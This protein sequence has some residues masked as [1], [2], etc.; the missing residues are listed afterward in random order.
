MNLAIV[1]A[2]LFLSPT[3]GVIFDC[4]FIYINVMRIGGIYKCNVTNLNIQSENETMSGVGGVHKAQKQDSDVQILIIENQLCQ[5]LPNDIDRHFPN[6]YH[7][8]IRNSGLLTVDSKQ[9]KMFPKLRHLYIR[10][11]PIEVLPDNLFEFNP[12]L[13][14]INLNDNRI[15]RIGENVFEPLTKL[16]SLS[17]ERNICINN[18][19]LEEEPL[20][21]LIKEI[22]TKCSNE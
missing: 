16:I 1:A 20:K 12:L 17:V 18:F 4:E 6:A 13:E 9:M 2:A 11:N 19:A 10:N 5:F 3:L 8:D 21:E 7:L 14:F 22:A 15:K